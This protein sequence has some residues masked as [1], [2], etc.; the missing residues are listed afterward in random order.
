MQN[1]FLT[2]VFLGINKLFS[3]LAKNIVAV[4][5]LTFILSLLPVQAYSQEMNVPLYS[6]EDFFIFP[7]ITGFSLSNDGESLFF[8]SSVNLVLNVFK[9]DIATQEDVQLT[10]EE[11]QHVLWFSTKGDTLIY[12]QDAFGD[13]NFSIFRMNEDGTSTNLTP[14]EGVM[15]VPIDML[16][17]TY[18]D[19]EILIMMNLEDLTSFNIY[20][21]NIFT[22][23]F[24]M[25]FE[26]VDGL[27]LDNNGTARFIAV[28]EGEEGG[29]M[30]LYHRF[31]DDDEFELVGV[32]SHSDNFSIVG[33]NPT[34]EYIYAITNIG[35]NF[36]VLASVDPSTLEEIEIIFEHN[37][38][39]ISGAVVGVSSPGVL[40]LAVYET[41][42]LNIAFF[43][44]IVKDFYES[45]LTHFPENTQI[46][47]L[48]TSDDLRIGI[49]TIASDTNRGQQFIF[50]AEENSIEIL[51]DY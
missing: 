22:N 7:E 37:E 17:D 20:R 2:T 9:R 35:R 40:A 47:G 48:D 44:Q 19:E 27:V 26:A 8:I 34:N 6:V 23:E 1:K 50:N 5:T 30:S 29:N 36:N 51:L 42:F 24:E 14:F 39:D 49:I 12:I 11:E 25:V 38:V 3:P 28:I 33:F 46:V 41:D 32:I 31:T 43:D 18:A 45:A 21:L 13:E 10:F 4:L 15:A 16:E